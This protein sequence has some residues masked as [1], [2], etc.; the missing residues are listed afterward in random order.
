[1]FCA[2]MRPFVAS[3]R[4][5]L[6]WLDAFC[7]LRQGWEIRAYLYLFPAFK[8]AQ[9]L[10]WDLW[11]WGV[12]PYNAFFRPSIQVCICWRLFAF[13][14]LLMRCVVFLIFLHFRFLGDFDFLRFDASFD[15]RRLSLGAVLIVC[16]IRVQTRLGS[17]SIRAFVFCICGNAAFCSIMQFF[18]FLALR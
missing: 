13:S 12:L 6:C 1:M 4:E 14:E 18:A 9:Y 2:S 15:C 10:Y 5:E 7:A 16:V 8:F 17:A 11:L 3:I